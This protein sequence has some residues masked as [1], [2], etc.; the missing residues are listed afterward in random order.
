MNGRQ[1]A[2]GRVK[3][4]VNEGHKAERELKRISDPETDACRD[5]IAPKLER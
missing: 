2:G 4:I 3:N 5:S 1:Y